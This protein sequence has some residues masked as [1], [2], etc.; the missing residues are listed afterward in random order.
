[1]IKIL[2]FAKK[3]W[4][5][6]LIIVLLLFVQANCDL[7]LPEY[8][9]DI[10]DVGIQSKGIKSAVL[11]KMRVETYEALS[12]FMDE[13]E[14]QFFSDSYEL[15]N[16]AYV[17]TKSEEDEDFDSL[18]ELLVEKEMLLFM[19]ESEGEEADA[20]K[21]QMLEKMGMPEDTE[22]LTAFSMMP[23]EKVLE[24]GDAILEKLE[25][26]SAMVSESA[27]KSF[28]AAEYDA[29]G[30]NV[31]K[32]QMSYLR[33]KGLLMLGIA[34][35]GMVMAVSV[36]FL[37]AKL[38]AK[39]AK[40]L[41]KKVFKKVVSFSNEE[42]NGFSTSSLIT[43]CTNDIQQ[44][45]MVL[46]MIFR[47]VAY[48]PLIGIGGIIKV[49]NTETQMSWIIAVAVAAVLL[50][51]AVLMVVAMPKFKKMQTLIDDLNLV[52]RETL[53]GISVIRAFG[54]EEYE[55][56]RFEKSSKN[57]MKTQLFTHKAMAFMMPT[58]MFIMNA[59]TILII[60]VGAHGIN[61]GNL[62]VG[63]MMAFITYTMQIVM[64]FLMITMVSVMLPRAAVAAVRIDEVLK[65]K[66]TIKNSKEPKELTEASKGVISFE[67]VNFAYPGAEEDALKD[68][69]F[70]AN[71][72]E[73]TAIIGSTGCG[74]STLV[75][76][77]PRLYDIRS[78]AIKIDDV[79]VREI[80]I[81]QLRQKIGYVPQK[82]ILFSG[83][84]K[85][86][87]GFGEK[88][89]KMSNIEEAA[90]IA[91]AE[92]FIIEKPD[93]YEEH[94]A[95]GGSNVSGGQKQRLSIARAIARN[96]KIYIFDDS[97]SALDY[98]TD[99][100]LRKALSKKTKDATVIIVAQRIST[101]L[102]ADKILVLDDG[103]VVGMGTHKELLAG[104]D[105]YRQI[106]ASQLSEEELNKT[107]NESTGKEE[108]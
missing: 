42:I 92:E 32:I 70:S 38:A 77:I 59:I 69:T 78:G 68:I 64:A 95:Q 19:L 30:V 72:G 23:K 11:E 61:L 83:T 100:V 73:T 3:S 88:D 97:F 13:K 39:T 47:I 67:H 58:M 12:L 56:E 55:Q 80:D 81:A 17:L 28:V 41:R 91:Q 54:R 51:V 60:W 20:V 103:K 96:P 79:D 99:Q 107:N 22:I 10:V 53:T 94:I 25:D 49:V 6:M 15:K 27:A 106:A 37:S 102:N 87:I 52:S 21:A 82:G 57:L 62:Q 65:T 85:S 8:T 34:V 45:Q 2:K 98:K 5:I 66:T 101:I 44:V 71:P 90:K 89:P 31:D 35:I 36:N 74:K 43:R 63:D 48:A 105:V 86:N 26:M 29:L 16:D 1:M 75:Q 33:N 18:E 50:L 40:D 24:I 76:L 108:A 7:A 9:S 104:N 14:E 46:T 84:I 93:T 4:Y